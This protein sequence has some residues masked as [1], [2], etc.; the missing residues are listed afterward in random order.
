MKS[1]LSLTI[2]FLCFKCAACSLFNQKSIEEENRFFTETRAFSTVKDAIEKHKSVLI[3]GEPGC[4][5]TA[6]M[7]S[8]GFFLWQN[9][10]ILREI[11]G[12][13][14]IKSDT[15]S[16]SKILY[17]LDNAF[18]IF[19]FDVSFTDDLKHYKDIN[20][21]LND[22]HSKL[23]MTCRRSV[24][25]KMQ[26]FN[27]CLAVQVIDIS[28]HS[29]IL[30]CEEKM[31]VFKHLVCNQ[32]TFSVNDDLIEMTICCTHHCF[33]LLCVLFGD[34]VELQGKAKDL[35][36][37]PIKTF[38]SYLDYIQEERGSTYACLVW[39]VLHGSTQCRLCTEN[40]CV[41]LKMALDSCNRRD[42][43]DFSYMKLQQ[44]IKA[45]TCWFKNIN[46][47][48]DFRHT[49]VFEMMAYHYGQRN[50][51][52]VIASLASNFINEKVFVR[53]EKDKESVQ[54]LCLYVENEMLVKRMFLD[55]QNL[56]YL[57]VFTNVCWRDEMF[58]DMFKRALQTKTVS[59]TH[60]LFF[61]EKTENPDKCTYK[62]EV[63]N[64]CTKHYISLKSNDFEWFRQAL[65]NDRRET[66]G[67][68]RI[69]FEQKAKAINWVFGFGN[70]HLL[71][72]LV[73]TEDYVRSLTVP[74][75]KRQLI[76]AIFSKNVKCMDIALD[77]VDSANL[78]K[79]CIDE[80][81]DKTY[82]LNSH[83]KFTALTAA[84]YIGFSE[85]IVKLVKKGADVNKK[86]ENGNAPL[87]LACRFGI[88]SDLTYLMEKKADINCTSGKGITPLIAAVMNRN[89][90]MVLFLLKQNIDVNQCSSDGKDPLYYAVKNDNKGILKLL[91]DEGG[92]TKKI[93][94]NGKFLLYVAAQNGFENS[95]DYLISN[96]A[97]INQYDAKKKT[98]L[99]CASKQGHINLVQ[100]LLEK[101]ATVNS[102]TIRN[103]TPLYVAAKIGQ[104]QI[105]EAL[106]NR[107]ANVDKMDNEGYTPL[108]WASK[109]N[110]LKIVKLLL[111]NGALPNIKTDE[112]ETALHAASQAGHI[113]IIRHLVE[114]KANVNSQD[115]KERT[116]L[117][118]ASERGHL[119]V[120][121][122]LISNGADVNKTTIN[123]E[124]ALFITSKKGRIDV[125][126]LLI[127]MG[128]NVN[129]VNQKLESPLYVAAKCGHVE[130][131]NELLQAKADA[132][133][134][135]ISNQTALYWAT[136]G[137]YLKT[138]KCLLEH[139]A[140]VNHKANRDKS[141]LYCASKRGFLKIVQLLVENKADVNIRN[142]KNQ[143]PLFRACKRNHQRV[144]EYLIQHGADVNSTDT[145]GETPLLWASANGHYEVVKLLCDI[146]CDVNKFS[147]DQETPLYRAAKLGHVAI[148]KYLLQNGANRE[149]CDSCKRTPLDFA[150]RNCHTE[151]IQMLT[152]E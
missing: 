66:I 134:A 62:T 46:D 114:K 133:S 115:R 60:T 104:F 71:S 59:D 129:L 119:E 63:S 44:M 32:R 116:P 40:N 39:V 110:F 65:L 41:K 14:E 117:Y 79:T 139:G 97:N 51:E 36:Q 15:T 152:S 18:G 127:T 100:L 7:Q 80:Y 89:T 86:D 27:F 101:G 140:V 102:P 67:G 88:Y 35:F 138:T 43:D 147:N 17:L 50:E 128:A 87:V 38:L 151:I 106:I 130:V 108:Y 56:N 33:P 74:E 103:K 91:V 105:C 135:C 107:K 141:A 21:L 52:N 150:T 111:E 94:K 54:A 6:L 45:Q 137:G 143:T 69:Q 42:T 93:Y 1:I 3:I 4:G 68:D 13:G 120:V 146:M 70:H 61:T 11:S 144:A 84:C 125:V 20:L 132:N 25:N 2:F 126:K 96:D 78:N 10:Y 24:Y 136:Q 92:N 76:L 57:D 26:R 55:I 47:I 142:N 31:G 37:D 53:N 145:Q 16:E 48:Y 34:F 49:L 83:K 28:D 22:K 81:E 72:N 118:Y 8:V 30:N 9:D 77:S 58:C 99:F 149:I 82:H 122:N 95:A 124:S 109:R 23:L 5:K 19:N 75:R 113:D 123:S 64:E 121:K 73:K 112:G 98:P 29:L 12:F 85:G 131:V 90:D 148:C